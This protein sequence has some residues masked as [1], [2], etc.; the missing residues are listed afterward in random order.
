MSKWSH[1]K[2][3]VI[4]PPW[5]SWMCFWKALLNSDLPREGEKW[6]A[7]F[8]RLSH[9]YHDCTERNIFSKWHLCSCHCEPFSNS[10]K[11]LFWRQQVCAPFT[12]EI[13]LTICHPK[14]SLS[15][16]DSH[17]DYSIPP[18]KGC[19]LPCGY[20]QTVWNASNRWES[21]NSTFTWLN[22]SSNMQLQD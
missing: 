11:F 19:A 20:T 16:E 3:Q 10:D 12:R 4:Y 5:A 14:E 8:L 1:V 22:I 15:C 6:T 2:G 17:F 21:Q 7:W 9:G 13:P 18:K